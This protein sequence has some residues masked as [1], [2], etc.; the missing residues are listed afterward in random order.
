MFYEDTDECVKKNIKAD[1]CIFISTQHLYFEKYLKEEKDKMI[2]FCEI[3][4]AR[5]SKEQNEYALSLLLSKEE[6]HQKA[7][8]SLRAA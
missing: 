2:E 7:R 6:A 3:Q 8:A 4:N 5:Y 1:N